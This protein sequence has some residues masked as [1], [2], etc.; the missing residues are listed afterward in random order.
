MAYFPRITLCAYVMDKRKRMITLSDFWQLAYNVLSTKR[1]EKLST[2]KLPDTNQ[3]QQQ[4][5]PKKSK[6][7]ADKSKHKNKPNW[8]ERSRRKVKSDEIRFYHLKNAAVSIQNRIVT[9]F[10][11]NIFGWFIHSYLMVSGVLIKA[12]PCK[13]N[14]IVCRQYELSEDSLSHLFW[15]LTF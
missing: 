13:A 3:Q 4:Q 5:Q 14:R 2:E 12:T 1:N 8:K 9:N 11:N 15:R 7:S 6:S 10:S